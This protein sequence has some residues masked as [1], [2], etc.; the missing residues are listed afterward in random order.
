MVRKQVCKKKFIGRCLLCGEEDYRLLEAHR[1]NKGG[2]CHE[3]ILTCCV[4]CHTLVH[5]GDI[6]ILGRHWVH[7]E[8]PGWYWMV[9]RNGA[10]ELI[11][12]G[13]AD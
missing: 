4:R 9:R 11:L 6:E 7:G 5:A 13:P 1:P 3:N 2:Y 12:D 10:T 8:R